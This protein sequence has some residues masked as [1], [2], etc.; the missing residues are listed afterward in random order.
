MFYLMFFN[1]GISEA[2][3]LNFQAFQPFFL[4]KTICLCRADIPVTVTTMLFHERPNRNGRRS[5]LKIEVML[6]VLFI[7]LD[8]NIIDKVYR[9]IKKNCPKK[10]PIKLHWHS[11]QYLLQG[12]ALSPP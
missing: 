3:V 4:E 2:F 5:F 1:K 8:T 7:L 12:N 9:G 10:D 6:N 11:I